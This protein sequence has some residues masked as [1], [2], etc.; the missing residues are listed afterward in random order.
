MLAP[1]RVLVLCYLL[2]LSGFAVTVS[3]AQQF[4]YEVEKRVLDRLRTYL[5]DPVLTLDFLR[6]LLERDGFPHHLNAPDR[7]EYLAVSHSLQQPLV[8]YGSETGICVG[9]YFGLGYHREP[10]YSG[11]EIGDTNV[12]G[13][14]YFKTCV[15]ES[16]ALVDCLHTAG[17]KYIKKECD[18]NDA[19][20]LVPCPDEVSQTGCDYDDDDLDAEAQEECEKAIKWCS[21]YSIETVNE[22]ETLGYIPITNHCH[23]TLGQFSE[24]VEGVENT[25]GSGDISSCYHSDGETLV[26]RK[27]ETGAFAYCGGNGTVCSGMFEGGYSSS[28][29]DPRYRYVRWIY[30]CGSGCGCGY[31]D[32]FLLGLTTERYVM[33]NSDYVCVSHL[34]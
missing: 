3:S 31:V 30:G 6:R 14:A 19:T 24:V 8:Y 33:L 22:G 25:D 16:G 17:D 9:Y 34:Y 28:N 26:Q 5:G 20:C 10:G 1:F 18:V 21:T 32:N 29:Y 2:L 27:D 4:N 12:D 23:N 7:D 15:D 13:M 11:Y